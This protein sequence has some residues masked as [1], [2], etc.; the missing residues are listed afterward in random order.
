MTEHP[1]LLR[2]EL[3]YDV[4]AQTILDTFV[5]GGEMSDDLLKR[6]LVA[7]RNGTNV[8]EV[9]DFDTQEELGLVEAQATASQSRQGIYHYTYSRR[10]AGGHLV[11]YHCTCEGFTFHG[12]CKH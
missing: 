11:K 8:V 2:A 6:A 7:Q 5:N 10:V 3:V 4:P 12:N 1:E 9:R